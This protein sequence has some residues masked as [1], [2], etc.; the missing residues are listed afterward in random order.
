M[1]ASG[2]PI[3]LCA[4]KLASGGDVLCALPT[5]HHMSVAIRGE[6]LVAKLLGAM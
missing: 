6:L 4:S 3:V 5:F 2:V 1:K